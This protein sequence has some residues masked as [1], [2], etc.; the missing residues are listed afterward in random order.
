MSRFRLFR[1]SL[2]QSCRN[3]PQIS[4]GNAPSISKISPAFAVRDTVVSVTIT[5]TNFQNGVTVRLF[6][7]G[8]APITATV[9]LG[10]GF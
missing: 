7:A 1:L 8:S 6:K 3:P 4:S 5:G 2:R 9:T 10:N